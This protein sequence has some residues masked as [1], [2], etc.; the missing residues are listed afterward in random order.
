MKDKGILCL[1]KRWFNV[2]TLMFTKPVL[3]KEINHQWY[4]T[5]NGLQKLPYDA[6]FQNIQG[7]KG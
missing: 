3:K 2:L 4:Q 6:F 7:L 5:F 1:F